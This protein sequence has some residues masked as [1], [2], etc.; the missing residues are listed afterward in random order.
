MRPIHRLSE[1]DGGRFYRSPAGY[2]ESDLEQDPALLAGK[3]GVL[4]KSPDPEDRAEA[5]RLIYLLDRMLFCPDGVWVCKSEY[6]PDAQ[7]KRWSDRH[8]VWSAHLT[9]EQAEEWHKFWVEHWKK[10]GRHDYGF[11]PVHQENRVPLF[12]LIHPDA[13][14]GEGVNDL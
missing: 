9:K 11:F 8:V 7:G 5:G 3:I 6:L 13:R 2:S 12:R 14:V 10:K 4:M 1:Y